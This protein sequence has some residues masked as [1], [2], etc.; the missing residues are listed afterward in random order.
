MS[1]ADKLMTVE[2]FL[3]IP[4]DGIY[5]ELW[6]GVVVEYPED[7][8]L[9]V[10]NRFHSFTTAK[11]TGILHQW[12]TQAG[13]HGQVHSGDVGV[14]LQNEPDTTIGIDVAYFSAETMARQTEE[15]TII[16]GAPVLAVEVNSPSDSIERIQNK[17][18]A[19]LTHGVSLVWIANPYFRTLQIHRRGAAPIT[20]NDTQDFAGEELLP[21][22][23]FGVRDL[24]FSESSEL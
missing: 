16:V 19:Y 6:R 8:P 4:D 12:R 5:R 10:R 1:V 2:E 7:K 24:F 9:S 20:L 23:T 22:L 14:V 13:Q 21:G 15:T 3:A 11:I 18:Q 17:V